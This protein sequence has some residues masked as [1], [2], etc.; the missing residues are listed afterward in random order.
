MSCDESLQRLNLRPGHD[1]PIGSSPVERRLAAGRSGN[2][3]VDAGC[4][5]HQHDRHD[6]YP[7]WEQC[8]REEE[9]G[10]KLERR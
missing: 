4:A 2:G 9:P 6:Q 5:A 10:D 1:C 3:G 7:E 8:E